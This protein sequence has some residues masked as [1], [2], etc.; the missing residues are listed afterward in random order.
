MNET[1]LVARAARLWW[2]NLP[3]LLVGSVL[4]AAAW[5]LIRSLTAV[6]PW[7][8]VVGIGLVVL[9]LLA[10]LLDTCATLLG[11]EHAGVQRWL[12]R[13]PATVWRTWRVTVP[14][15]VV[16]LLASVAGSTWQHAGQLWMLGCWA[17]CSAVLA[18]LA[19]VAVIA[20]PYSVQSGAD[21]R[22][23]WLVSAY[24]ATRAP[25]PVL[26]IA[27]A[28]GL[29]AWASG[30][31]SFAVLLLVPAPVALVWAAG[32]IEVTRRGRT[33]LASRADATV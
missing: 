6:S 19:L 10:G 9:P 32:A 16:A 33:R 11:D 7:L 8:P 24:L 5:S 14:V 23:V 18:G 22:E 12:R 31:L 21:A 2:P 4:V 29:T 3:T 28:C 17:V 30:H 26:G 15:V 27:A 20:L 13:L 25:L 1:D